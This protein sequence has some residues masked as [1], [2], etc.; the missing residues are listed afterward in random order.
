M[1]TTKDKNKTI[2][3]KQCATL[4][5]FFEYIAKKEYKEDAP[6]TYDSFRAYEREQ[7][8]GVIVEVSVDGGDDVLTFLMLDG[9]VFLDNLSSYPI[10]KIVFSVWCRM[11]GSKNNFSSIAYIRRT[12]SQ[13]GGTSR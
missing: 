2:L 11:V 13:E 4:L 10:P 9:R 3:N 12:I 1:V 8:G 6:K 7:V 5:K